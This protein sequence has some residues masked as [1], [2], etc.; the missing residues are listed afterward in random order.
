[1]EITDKLA[2]PK[3]PDSVGPSTE[4]RHG[5]LGIMFIVFFVVSAASPLSVVAGGFPLG[6]MLGNGPGTPALVVAAL[7][8]LL[9]FAAGYTA[10]ATKIT[11]AGGFYALIARGL[12]VQAGGAAAMIAVLGYNTLQF[13][14]YGMFGAVA[15]EAVMAQFG[16]AVPWWQCSLVAMASIAVFGYR[17]I[18]FSAKVLAGFVIA[19]YAAMLLLDFSI[20]RVGGDGGV[21]AHSFVP[22]NVL[23]GNPSIGLLFCFAAFIGFEATAIYG[24]EAKD[25]HRSIPIA[26]Y[27][28]LLII[29]GFYAFSVWC[30]LIG[31]GPYK[32]A[33][34]ILALDE[35]TK[36]V[37][38]LSDRYVGPTLTTVLRGMFMISVYAGLIAFHNSIA[39][40]LYALGRS[41]VLP[42]ILGQ[43]HPQ[44][45]S[46]HYASIVQSVLSLIVVGF[47]AAIGADPV[48]TLFAWLSNLATLSV[49]ILM[50]MTSAAV[51]VFFRRTDG[52]PGIVRVRIMPVLSAIGLT[53]VLVLAIFHFNALTGASNLV[54]AALIGLLPLAAWLGV[55]LVRRLKRKDPARYAR[56]GADHS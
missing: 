35:P 10:M 19:E 47:F 24:E 29:G 18:D 1:M 8:L 41:R 44:H 11:N 27:A 55:V 38:M 9:C 32:A 13:A 20:L 48:R 56:I 31:A 26:T 14:L 3:A 43:T 15:S 17:Q 37:Y 36:F 42:G 7:V 25:P 52:G 28:A 6:I 2:I 12:G 22:N 40:Y 50:V 34:M 21:N 33:G 53:A 16:V 54:A 30:L 5:A 23:S 46:P 39:R 49:L 45:R 51:F 4:L